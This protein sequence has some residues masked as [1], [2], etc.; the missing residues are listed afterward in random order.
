VVHAQAV[1]LGVVGLERKVG[2]A[3]EALV[4][5]AV[6]VDRASLAVEEADEIDL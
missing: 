3:L 6:R 1:L 2:K 5:C 4:G